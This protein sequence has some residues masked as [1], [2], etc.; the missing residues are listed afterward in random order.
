MGDWRLIDSGSAGGARNMAL[1]LAL[2]E[3][4]QTGGSPVLRFYGWRPATLSLGRNQTVRLDSRLRAGAEARGV[5][6]VRRPTGGAAVLHDR[7]L[8]YTVAVPVGLLGSPRET[9]IAIN[10]ALAAGLVRLGVAASVVPASSPGLPPRIADET[11]GGARVG[12]QDPGLGGACFRRGIPGEVVVAG[13][14]L[15]GSAQRCERRTLLQHGSLLLEGSQASVADL[16]ADGADEDLPET[17]GTCLA[18]HLPALPDPA[19]L[20]AELVAGFEKVLGISLA[21]GSPNPA[22]ISRTLALTERFSSPEWTWRR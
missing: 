10:R 4:V 19:A 17:G 6:I 2:F 21:P 3:A 13:R 14:K 5:E 7:E 8:T 18:E 12:R 11:A 16:L 1:D 9:Y 22:E 15:V 20:V